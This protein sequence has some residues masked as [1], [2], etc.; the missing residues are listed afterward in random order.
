MTPPATPEGFTPER[1]MIAQTPLVIIAG[2]VAREAEYFRENSG[3]LI[4]MEGEPSTEGYNRVGTVDLTIK[5]KR[6]EAYK[7]HDEKALARALLICAAPDLAEALRPFAEFLDALE[8]MGGNTPKTGAFYTLN[9]HGVGERSIT[10]EHFKAARAAI[11]R[12]RPLPE[13]GCPIC[14]GDCAGANPPV[15]DCPMLSARSTKQRE[16]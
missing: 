15:L 9:A 13:S 8:M 2:K 5:A 6:G 3:A 16:K 14:N 10:I 1:W 11:S 4:I 7:T 12:A